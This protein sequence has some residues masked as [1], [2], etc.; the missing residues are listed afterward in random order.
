MSR[1]E[2]MAQVLREICPTRA[3]Q[4]LAVFI[5]LRTLVGDRFDKEIALP[6]PGEKVFAYLVPPG[7]RNRRRL[8]P[9]RVEELHRCAVAIQVPDQHEPSK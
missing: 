7:S 1:T 9:E 8:T 5:L 2:K 3:E 6:G 4:E